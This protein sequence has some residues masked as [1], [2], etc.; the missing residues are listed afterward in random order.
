LPIR[1]K[2]F[3]PVIVLVLVIV[4]DQGVY[5][6]RMFEDEHE[7]EDEDDSVVGSLPPLEVAFAGRKLLTEVAAS[8]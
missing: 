6:G 3:R 1:N 8:K 4:L 5:R 7:N 2:L